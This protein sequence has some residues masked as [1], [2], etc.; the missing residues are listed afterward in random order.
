MC[1]PAS[2]LRLQDPPMGSHPVFS[3]CLCMVLFAGL[4]AAHPSKPGQSPPPQPP[5]P[6]VSPEVHADGSVTVR[7]RAPNVQEVELAREGAEPVAMRKDDQG[8]WSVTTAALAPDFYGYSFVDDGLHLS[9][10]SNPPLKPN[11]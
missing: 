9:D 6:L 5:P 3:S 8:V 2:L 7:F 4:T 11:L 10:P 1:L